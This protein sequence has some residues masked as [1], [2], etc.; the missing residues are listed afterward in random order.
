MKRIYFI[1]TLIVSAFIFHS[2]IANA[3]GMAVNTT[4]AA[5]DSS[6][7]LDLNTTSQGL[8]PPRM[9]TAQ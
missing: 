2:D 7:I 1:A 6:A 5:A 9:T 3:Q 8:L 4:R